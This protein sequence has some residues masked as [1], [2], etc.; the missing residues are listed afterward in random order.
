MRITESAPKAR[1]LAPAG[2]Q[3]ARLIHILDF[4]THETEFQGVKK[5]KRQVRL[6]WELVD[7]KM[8]DGKNFV[9]GKTYNASLFK[10]SLLDA[11]ESMTGKPI[12]F[13]HDGSFDMGTLLG[14]PCML[15]VAHNTKDGKTFAVPAGMSPL[16]TIKGKVIDCDE[17]T[18]HLLNFS[19]D[20]F[21]KD[22]Y[23]M[24]PEWAQKVIQTSPE[25]IKVYN[26]KQ[27]LPF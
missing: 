24:I 14:K 3:C 5:N 15:T 20:Y 1:E 27:D 26:E 18:N 6:T 19:L 22:V 2:T 12:E 7:A 25:W 10:S 21:D 13:E 11:I 16:P 17:A 8:A 23:D 4:G 9:I